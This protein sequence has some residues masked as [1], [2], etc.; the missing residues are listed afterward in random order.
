MKLDEK[1][2]RMQ[3]FMAKY[4]K[5]LQKKYGAN[6]LYLAREVEDYEPFRTHFP[7]FD[8]MNSGIG[9]FPRGGMTL[10]HGPESCGKSTFVVES[11]ANEFSYNPDS[12]GLYIDAENTMTKAYFKRKK[13]DVDR[14]ALTP[15]NAAEDALTIAKDA[16]RENIYDIVVIDSLAKL[17]S[18]VIIDNDIGEKAQRNRRAVLLT[19]FFK[20]ISLMLRN[21]KTALVCINQEV[22]NQDP[23]PWAPKKLLPGGEQQRYSANLRIEVKR[24][25]AL[26]DGDRHIGYRTRFTTLKSKISTSERVISEMIYLLDRGF[27]RD[28]SLLEYLLKIN[29]LKSLP[30]KRYE[31]KDKQMYPEKFKPSEMN[32][33]VNYVLETHGINLFDI[34]PDDQI[35]FDKDESYDEDKNLGTDDAGDIIAE[36]EDASETV[37]SED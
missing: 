1:I 17:D 19:E 9:G 11:I 2:S 7:T 25:K 24:S 33:I 13:I 29:Y 35:K 23:S 14:L 5:Q 12:L 28:F 3:D 30:Q 31:F 15:M 32:K 20:T 26:K 4:N 16:I 27:M 37:E 18:Q 6:V 10:V 21:S 8:W 36:D 34:E 22:I